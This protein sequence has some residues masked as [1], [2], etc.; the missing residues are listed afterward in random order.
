MFVKVLL[1]NVIDRPAGRHR[2]AR[3]RGDDPVNPL[4]ILSRQRDSFCH[5]VTPRVCALV[6]Q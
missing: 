1:Y 3:R 6:R 2:F 5:A 4:L